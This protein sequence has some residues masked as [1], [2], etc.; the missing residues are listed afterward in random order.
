METVIKYGFL[1]FV[2]VY[3][4]IGSKRIAKRLY[5][6]RMKFEKFERTLQSH[7]SKYKCFTNNHTD[8]WSEVDFIR[9]KLKIADSPEWNYHLLAPSLPDDFCLKVDEVKKHIYVA[10]G[11]KKFDWDSLSHI[12]Q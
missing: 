2:I 6:N 7:S 3:F 9:L 8:I 5:L 12:D 11:S 1:A 10:R 4:A